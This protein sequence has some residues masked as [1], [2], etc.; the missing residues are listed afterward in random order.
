MTET[1]A[2]LRPAVTS[3]RRAGRRAA[4][5]GVVLAVVLTGQLMAI[6]DVNIVNVAVPAIH[7]SLH[8]TG[9]PTRC[10]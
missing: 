4:S 5:P 10:C 3:G 9:S 8:T 6:I 1:T 2:R 7:S